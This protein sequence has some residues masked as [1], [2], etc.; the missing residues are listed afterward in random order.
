[1]ILATGG[2]GHRCDQNEVELGLPGQVEC[3]W[4]RHHPELLAISADDPHLTGP[5]SVVDRRF[6]LLAGAAM[7]ASLRNN[8]HL[9]PETDTDGRG[10]PTSYHTREPGASASTQRTPQAGGGGVVDP[11]FLD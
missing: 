7:G 5:Y 6:V 11:A 3:L 10:K 1:M 4:K 2:F 8:G 9:L